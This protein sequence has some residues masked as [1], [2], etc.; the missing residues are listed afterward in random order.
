MIEYN[1]IKQGKVIELDGQPHSVLDS[2]VF[3][4]QQRKPV[5]QTKLR[6]L[7]TGNIRE[8]TFQQSDKVE[9]ANLEKKEITYIYSKPEENWFHNKENKGERFFLP[10]SVIGENK[11]YLKERVDV[12]ALIFY[13]GKSDDWKDNII[14]IELP[15]KMEFEVTEAPPNIK[16]STAQGGNK[17]VTIE[18]GGSVTTPMF[19]EQGDRI[20]VN[21]QTG[22]YVERAK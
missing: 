5:N 2:R 11:K 19:I 7:V 20:V 15:I 3:R 17:M 18:T 12:E 1:Q 16:G 8:Q 9:E 14:G 4:K 10:D 6:N 21:T 13:S 22:E